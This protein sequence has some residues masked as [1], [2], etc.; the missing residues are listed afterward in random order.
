MMMG[1]HSTFGMFVI[2]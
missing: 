1:I 2:L